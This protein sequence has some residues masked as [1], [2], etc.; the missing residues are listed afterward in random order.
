MKTKSGAGETAEI[1]KEFLKTQPIAGLA[2]VVTNIVPDA[3]SVNVSGST[4]SGQAGIV[5]V[6]NSKTATL[7]YTR[8]HLRSMLSSAYDIS[9]WNIELSSALPEQRFDFLVHVPKASEDI[10]KLLLCQAIKSVYGA[11]VRRVKREKQVLLLRHDKSSAQPGLAEAASIGSCSDGRDRIRSTGVKMDHL[12][13]S[14]EGKLGAPVV[15]ETG[16]T[17]IYAVNLD[18]TGGSRESLAAAL[19]DQLGMLLVPAGRMTDTLEVFAAGQIFQI[20]SEVKS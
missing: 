15:D 12:A 18:W 9:E 16:L 19:K 3:F 8:L 2:E 10:M 13:R 14:L 17:G 5:Y 11:E 7:R 4:D 20:A 6:S 1:V